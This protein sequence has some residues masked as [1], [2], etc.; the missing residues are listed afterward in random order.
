MQHQEEVVSEEVDKDRTATGFLTIRFTLVAAP[1][2]EGT[3]G[4]ADQ[5]EVEMA[6][7]AFQEEDL[8]EEETQGRDLTLA[9]LTAAETQVETTVAAEAAEAEAT[10]QGMSAP[11]LV[12]QE[13]IFRSPR[14]WRL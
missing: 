2:S 6:E 9:V 10:A 3:V 11:V 7:A 8:L 4:S 13:E 12:D 5:E 14:F 1:R